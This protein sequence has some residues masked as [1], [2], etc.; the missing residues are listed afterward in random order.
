[1]F[2]SEPDRGWELGTWDRA[3]GQ[4]MLE[5]SWVPTQGPSC[6]PCCPPPLDVSAQNG[7]PEPAL[8]GTGHQGGPAESPHTEV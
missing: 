6:P 5:P 8:G 3:L 7:N 4:G 1:M 2:C